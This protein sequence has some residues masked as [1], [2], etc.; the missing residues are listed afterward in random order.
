M[1]GDVSRT[2]TVGFYGKVPARGDFVRSGLPRDFID[3]WDDWLSGVMLASRE[4]AGDAWLPAYL[5]APIWRFVLP[6]G[7]CGVHA[8]LGL[9]MPSVD[10][11]GRYFPLTFAVLAGSARFDPASGDTWLDR[12]EDA[13]RAALEQ[14]F[15]PDQISAMLGS[16]DLA[17]TDTP[18]CHSEWWTDGSVRLSAGRMTCRGLPDAD[19]YATMLGI[20]PETTGQERPG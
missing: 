2:L 14:D 15:S 6:P 4:Q 16:P 13:G 12:C 11:A 8:A 1:P 5:E 20:A 3:A 18:V 7:L 9:M 17:W 19:D 10:R